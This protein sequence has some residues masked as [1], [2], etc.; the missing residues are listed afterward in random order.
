M[1][2]WSACKNMN[3]CRSDLPVRIWISIWMN[4]CRSDPCRLWDFNFYVIFVLKMLILNCISNNTCYCILYVI[5][6]NNIY[7]YQH[8]FH[9]QHK[10]MKYTGIE[11]MLYNTLLRLIPVLYLLLVPSYFLTALPY[12]EMSAIENNSIYQ[13]F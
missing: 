2:I 13:F 4:K 1:Q 12:W 10:G 7:V 9:L 11:K 5:V 6:L 3:K 8:I